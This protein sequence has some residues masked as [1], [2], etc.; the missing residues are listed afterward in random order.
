MKKFFAFLFIF[1]L[2]F[3][4]TFLVLKFA[5]NSPSKP[6]QIIKKSASSLGLKEHQVVGFLPYWLISKADKDYSKYLTTITYFGL[7][8]NPDG[9][10]QKY[11][12][13]GESEPGWYALNSD[14][15]IPPQAL[16]KSLLVFSGEPEAINQLVSEPASHAATF[17]TQVTP[18]MEQY[19]FTDL[20]LDVENVL[21]ASESAR[22]NFTVFVR[23]LKK[24][25]NKL[26]LASASGIPQAEK[27]VSRSAQNKTLTIDVSPTDL[28]KNRL[29]NVSEIEPYV[30]SVV[31][32]TYDY[33]YIGSFVTGPV[34]PLG[35]A[36][37]YSE[38]DTETGIQKALEVLPKDKIILGIPLYGYGWETIT[39]N[40][41][42]AV[43]PGTGIIASNRRVEELLAQCATCSAKIEP[44]AEESYLIYKDQKTSTYHQI[45]YPD[46][47]ATQTKINLANKYQ[48]GGLAFWALGYEGNTILNP[49]VVYKDSLK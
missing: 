24:G 23:E 7:V 48:L 9:S 2:G 36:G 29:I 13:P 47:Q 6:A 37:T 44:A 20:N 5:Y 15:F 33:H 28:I 3:G 21:P 12:K 26:P 42:A 16:K 43:I 17:V 39:D 32:M 18:I 8:I 19:G 38:F 25:I 22:K 30:D 11:T 35:G 49:V 1:C 41:R 10:I 27:F 31:L 34:A 4:V 14:K 45:F 46:A 40:P